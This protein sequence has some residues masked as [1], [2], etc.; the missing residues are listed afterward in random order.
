[1]KFSTLKCKKTLLPIHCRVEDIK[2]QLLDL[3]LLYHVC[4]VSNSNVN[5]DVLVF[6]VFVAICKSDV[7]LTTHFKRY[8]LFFGTLYPM[9]HEPIN[10]SAI[11]K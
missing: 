3:Q 4:F 7:A 8:Q 5:L 1:M 2:E 6:V 10:L 11:Q 9:I